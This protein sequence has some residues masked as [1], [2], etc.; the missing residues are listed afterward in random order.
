LL[1][2]IS[3]QDALPLLAFTL[4]HLYELYAADN[5]LSLSG[6]DRLGGLKGVIDT[7]VKQVFAE[8]VAKGE[9]PKDVK[10]QLALARA[11]FIPHLAQVNAAGQFVRRVAMRDQIP[12]EARPLIDRFADQR[13][14]MKDR[15]KDTDAKDVDVVEVA[16]EALLRQPPFSEWLAEDREF[17]MWRE[18]LS[19]A[20][21]AFAANER[22]LL[23]GRELQIA[24]G[25]VQTRAKDDIEPA[26]QA[27]IR[28][29]IAEDDKRRAE[30]A[31]QER[32]RQ[33]VEKEEQ[34]RRIHDAEQIA[35]EQKRAAAARWRTAQVTFVGLV[36]A[37]LVAVA[38][39]WQYF[40]AVE[41][42]NKAV[43]AT[44]VAQGKENSERMAKNFIAR[45]ADTLQELSG[46]V[47]EETESLIRQST[48]AIAA[49]RVQDADSLTLQQ[50]DALEEMARYFHDAWD[51]QR[52]IRFL[53]DAD[54][55][56]HQVSPAGAAT[57]EFTRLQAARLEIAGDQ[58][59]DDDRT[60]RP[61]DLIDFSMTPN[62]RLSA[63]R[64]Q[65][66]EF[67]WC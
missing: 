47:P 50:V 53:K 60:F 24:S 46:F 43:E 67:R 23:A 16:H 20:R 28:D 44:N 65:E 48:E 13:L 63:V 36:V 42:T 51:G 30:E 25:W 62:R 31:E 26:D 32:K 6:Y 19:Q 17:L 54:D 11:A 10:A 38:A 1:K 2:D 64:C 21:A 40:K 45:V 52:V 27:F 7:A 37:V 33:A 34:E 9:L 57:P 49:G 66:T 41:A 35:A 3:G 56:L 18:R 5:E 8:S 29:S 22:A 15:R 12:A 61:P 4:A 59:A 14:L 55:R 39:L 58:H